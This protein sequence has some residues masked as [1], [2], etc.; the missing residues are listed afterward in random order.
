MCIDNLKCT[1]FSIFTPCNNFVIFYE[2]LCCAQNSYP[3]C[4]SICDAAILSTQV[5]TEN[6]WPRCQDMVQ[7]LFIYIFLHTKVQKKFRSL[8]SIACHDIA[9]IDAVAYSVIGCLA[10]AL[11]WLHPV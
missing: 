11:V 9:V 8:L 2:N 3:C 4:N 5:T 1:H 6:M 7:L 10:K